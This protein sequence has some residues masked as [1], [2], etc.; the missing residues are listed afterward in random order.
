M[1]RGGEAGV[2]GPG[3]ESGA[4]V[5]GARLRYSCAGHR[6]RQSWRGDGKTLT[7]RA[8]SCKVRLEHKGGS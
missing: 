5:G 7:G 4:D 3:E 6:R 8:G 2:E 1:R